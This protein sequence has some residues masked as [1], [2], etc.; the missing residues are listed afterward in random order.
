MFQ[1]QYCTEF[2]RHTIDRYTYIYINTLY[3][4]NKILIY[5]LLFDTI[6]NFSYIKIT[7]T[8]HI[9]AILITE[10]NFLDSR[11]CLLISKKFCCSSF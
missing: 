6:N 8:L 4:P 1:I 11:I 10:V 3:I 9:L 2:T 7:A 5:I